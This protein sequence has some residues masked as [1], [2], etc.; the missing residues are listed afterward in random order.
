MVNITELHDPKETGPHVNRV[1]AISAELYE[2]W[3]LRKNMTQK[4]IEE[5]REIFRMA[6]MVHDVG[7][8]AI[9]DLILKKP[10]RLT[11]EEYELMKQHT[12][13]GARLFSELDSEF[14]RLS[15]EVALNHH[16]RWDGEGYPGHIDMK[17]GKPLPGCKK[18]DGTAVGKKGEEISIWSRI[19]AIADVYDALS[20]N[21]AYK[22]AWPQQQVF[23]ELRNQAGKQFDPELMDVFFSITNVIQSISQKYVD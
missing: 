21:R 19:V 23:R 8:I 2:A 22:K 9:S 14:D 11:S 10:A 15:A 12:Y 20:C 5:K 17:T 4:E 6:A 1:G 16:E 18:K 3:A 13:L 7:K